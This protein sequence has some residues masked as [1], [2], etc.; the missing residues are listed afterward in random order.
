MNAIFFISVRKHYAKQN[1]APIVLVMIT[2]FL[3]STFMR[4]PYTSRQATSIAE[5]ETLL[6]LNTRKIKQC[7]RK[8]RKA[9]SFDN[10]ASGNL[11]DISFSNSL[12]ALLNRTKQRRRTGVF[13]LYILFFLFYNINQH[14]WLRLTLC[15]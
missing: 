5:M 7:R 11:F 13:I 6:M 4:S 2:G 3:I 15:K 12:I 10:R 1:M 14:I 9:Y 8:W